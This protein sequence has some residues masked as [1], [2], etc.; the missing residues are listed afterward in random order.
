V[1]TDTLLRSDAVHLARELETAV[2][3]QVLSRQLLREARRSVDRRTGRYVPAL[4][5]T[6]LILDGTAVS[7]DDTQNHRTVSIRGFALNMDR[8]WQRLVG[9]VL[10]EWVPG[11]D[12]REERVLRDIFQNDPIFSPRPRPVPKPRPDFAVRTSANA[13]IFLDAKYRDMWKRDLPREMLYQLSLYAAAQGGGVATMLYPTEAAEAA[14]ERLRIGS[15]LAGGVNAAVALRPVHLGRLEELVAAAPSPGRTAARQAFSL[16]LSG[17]PVA[18][19]AKST[20]G[21]TGAAP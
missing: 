4:Q 17:I 9:R 12:V 20:L 3:P 19:N 5:L 1:A 6:E 2:T 8:L 14:E 13:E 21:A 16:G 11:I 10:R 18:G 7:L 15:L